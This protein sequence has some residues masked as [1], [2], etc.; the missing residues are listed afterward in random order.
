[1]WCKTKQEAGSPVRSR[2]GRSRLRDSLRVLV[3]SAARMGRASGSRQLAPGERNDR[4]RDESSGDRIRLIALRKW[5][6]LRETGAPLP[7]PP[8]EG[9]TADGRRWR[10]MGSFR[11][12]GNPGDPLPDSLLGGTL[13]DVL[14]DEQFEE[15]EHPGQ[16]HFISRDAAG[17]IP[18]D[19]FFDI[20]VTHFHAES[21]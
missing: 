21:H 11:I 1:M 17:D 6:R 13:G 15:Q 3:A 12:E 16:V 20:G 5:R 19:G 10:R 14:V 2:A 18:S 8:T 7:F 9:R 4:P